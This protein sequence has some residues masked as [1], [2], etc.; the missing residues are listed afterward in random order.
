[1]AAESRNGQP[2]EGKEKMIPRSWVFT[3]KN[4]ECGREFTYKDIDELHPRE[5]LN[6]PDDEPPKPPLPQARSFTCPHCN[7]GAVYNRSDLDLRRR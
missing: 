7:Q 5:V 2:C 6:N 4:R 1:M 3:C